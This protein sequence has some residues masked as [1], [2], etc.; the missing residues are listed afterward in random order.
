MSPQTTLVHLRSLVVGDEGTRLSAFVFLRKD[1]SVIPKGAE[2]HELVP[3]NVEDATCRI[4]FTT[5]RSPRKR[6]ANLVDM[7]APK[8]LSVT[9]SIPKHVLG[10]A[11]G[12]VAKRKACVI[13][14]ILHVLNSTQ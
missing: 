12:E 14:F 11:P 5:K 6:R 4:M 10:D 9:K 2:K 3:F 13:D 8:S 7:L 1:G